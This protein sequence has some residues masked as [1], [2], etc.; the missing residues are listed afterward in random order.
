MPEDVDP[1][2]LLGFGV[3]SAAREEAALLR[4]WNG[5]IAPALGAL[6]G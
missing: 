5:V 4:A 3:L 1:S 2:V 6:L